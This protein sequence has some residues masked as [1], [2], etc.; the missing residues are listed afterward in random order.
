MSSQVK[1]RILAAVPIESYIGRYVRLKASGNSLQG[2]CPFHKEK[3]PSFT[4]SPKRGFFYCFGCGKGGDIFH[5][6][7]EREKLSF[8][9]TLALLARH[10]GISLEDSSKKVPKK[11]AQLLELNAK[12]MQTFCDFLQAPQA[13]IHRDYLQKR[14]LNE[15]SI[16][17]FKLGASPERWEWLGKLYH[18]NEK[19]LLNLGLLR[20]KEESHPCYD[21]FR[22][23][24]L[25]P[26]LSLDKRPLAFGGRSLP[27]QDKEA[28]YINSPDSL[29][30]KKKRLL[31]GL[32]Q[33]LN[34]IRSRQEALLVEGYLDV[35]G[36]WQVGLRYACAPLG[37]SLS[38]E[39]L[40]SLSSYVKSLV[41]LFDGDSAGLRAAQ[42]AATLSLQET[43]LESWVCVLPP[44]SDP[45]D[46]CFSGSAKQLNLLL[47]HKVKASDFFLMES[48][49]PMKFQEFQQEEFQAPAK[50]GDLSNFAKALQS[51]YTGGMPS[52]LPKAMEKRVALD[53]LYEN[54]VDFSKDTDRRLLLEGAAS[55]LK[56]DSSELQ[57]EWKKRYKR[58]EYFSLYASSPNSEE[59]ASFLQELPPRDGREQVFLEESSLGGNS[60]LQR[61]TQKSLNSHKQKL[62]HCERQL[63]LELFS[64]PDLFY[65]F[66]KELTK[67]RF[68]DPHSEFFWRHLE[69]LY[70]LGNMWDSARP[71]DLELPED[72]YSIFSS[73]IAKRQFEE[74]SE[75]KSLF[76]GGLYIASEEEF[77]SGEGQGAKE[78]IED[79]FL[80]HEILEYE[81]K[82]DDLSSYISVADLSQKTQLIAKKGSLI[83]D[84]N[85]LK[86][87]WRYR[88]EKSI[89][90]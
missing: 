69:S 36:L 38:R 21:F 26:I 79:Y 30:F 46:L 63:L 76:P 64:H 70:L 34:E 58:K 73:L 71:I 12:V 65:H 54:L 86:D 45:F 68:S 83:R 7:M 19:E 41:F 35:I 11:E 44:G 22:N 89:N 85:H 88:L 47:E 2:L 29:L 37:T 24:I 72:S 80:K 17:F 49:L 55:I 48:L 14:G 10:A 60:G 82:I 51:Y 67:I 53:R 18:Q 75:E 77:G 4:V 81:K 23:R 84:L 61:N 52:L 25:F 28:K 20:Q 16:K 15:E 90:L 27:G 57:Q 32:S 66:N 56:L 1:E 43:N 59:A 39:H 13:K 9:E 78:L 87:Q 40:R 62:I 5:F 33:N 8:P 74:G 31:Y 50:K 42:R 3:T 6:V